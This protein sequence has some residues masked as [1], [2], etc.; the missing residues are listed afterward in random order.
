MKPDSVLVWDQE[1][2]HLELLTYNLQKEGYTVLLPESEEDVLPLS[3]S[4]SP[5][6]IILGNCSSDE[7][8]ATICRSARGFSEL[9]MT[10]I[11]CLTS[12][13]QCWD[14]PYNQTAGIDACVVF[15]AKPKKIIAEVNR[16]LSSGKASCC[17]P[18]EGVLLSGLGA[19]QNIAS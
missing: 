11:L 7:V 16:L 19:A 15:P 4:T 12:D 6:L 17:G 2:D 13:D 5:K 1:Q 8:R 18:K 9:F 10:P 14:R 3:R